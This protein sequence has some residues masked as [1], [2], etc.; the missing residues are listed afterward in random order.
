MWFPTTA[1]TPKLIDALRKLGVNDSTSDSA[2][3]C[4]IRTSETTYYSARTSP[5]SDSLLDVISIASTCTTVTL[6]FISILGAE[7]DR[8]LD[9]SEGLVSGAQ[10]ITEDPAFEEWLMDQI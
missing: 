1:D 6:D 9:P 10:A 2:S 5:D 4:T 7:V 3:T 8:A